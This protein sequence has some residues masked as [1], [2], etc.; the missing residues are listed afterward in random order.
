M[1]DISSIMPETDP[2]SLDARCARIRPS[3]SSREG[4][5]LTDVAIAWAGICSSR[6]VQGFEPGEP[7]APFA[8]GASVLPDRGV[9]ETLVRNLAEGGKICREFPDRAVVAGISGRF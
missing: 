3:W 9:I 2:W 8:T 5:A 4:D 7:L 6:L 1:G